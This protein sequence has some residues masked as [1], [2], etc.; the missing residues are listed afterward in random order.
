M[1]QVANRHG[2]EVYELEIRLVDEPAK[3]A[4]G[5]LVETAIHFAKSGRSIGLEIGSPAQERLL[6]KQQMRPRKNRKGVPAARMIPGR[7]KSDERLAIILEQ[8]AH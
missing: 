5:H 6:R 4:N 1:A 8:S 2:L 3:T 7:P